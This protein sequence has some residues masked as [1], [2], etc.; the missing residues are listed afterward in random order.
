MIRHFHSSPLRQPS[1]CSFQHPVRQRQ[2]TY[3]QS[4]QAVFFLNKVICKNYKDL[5]STHS[6]FTFLLITQNLN[7]IKTSHTRFCRHWLV[8]NVG[9]VS[10]KSIKLQGSWSSSKFSNFQEKYLV[11]QKQ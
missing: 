3:P 9:K 5:V 7:K 6:F 8:G 4:K 2:I 1:P 11:S 10:A